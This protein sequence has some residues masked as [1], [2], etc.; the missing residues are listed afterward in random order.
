MDTS[1]II[2]VSQFNQFSNF[3]NNA[4][5]ETRNTEPVALCSKWFEEDQRYCDI[6]NSFLQIFIEKGFTVKE[7]L[8]TLKKAK[9]AIKKS[10]ASAQ[11]KAPLECKPA[12]N[13]F[14]AMQ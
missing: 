1:I 14:A 12:K 8:H 11:W 4:S 5:I 2:H 9:F 13:S 3:M 10:M 7:S 6:A